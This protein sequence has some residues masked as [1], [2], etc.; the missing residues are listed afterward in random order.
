MP[1]LEHYQEAVAEGRIT[2]D[3][4][5][6]KAINLLQDI[7]HGLLAP[8][9]EQPKK[10]GLFGGMF[11]KRAAAEPIPPVKGA[12][13]WGGV[14]RGKTWI[15]DT[16]YSRVPIAEKRRMH[17]HHFMFF[18]HGEL[19][20]LSNKDNPLELI[21]AEM[22]KD[23]RLLCID[24]FHVLDIVDAMLLYGLLDAMFKHGVTLVTTSNRVPDDLYLNGLQRERFIPAIG[25]IKKYTTVL[26]LDNQVDYRMLKQMGEDSFLEDAATIQAEH[27]LEEKF[28][29]IAQGDVHTGHDIE[30]QGRHLATHKVADNIV[31][32]DFQT[33]C[34]TARSTRDYIELAER[35]RYI[36]LSGMH[37]LSTE[38]EEAARRFL[39]LLDELYDR[40][41]QFIFPTN[42]PLED[43]YQGEK[44]KFE[45][46]RALSR[47]NEM[48]SVSY[49]AS[50]PSNPN[51]LH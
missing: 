1:L 47:L 12:Y 30:V 25:L 43:L 6:L 51:T 26:E 50:E 7:W 23:T 35:F 46:Q 14:G 8:R 49:Q 11:A 20:K 3:P 36:M 16:F 38:H 28:A 32:F 34:E 42:F 39:N 2:R 17:Y 22:A 31:W 9:P 4:A 15:M 33:L 48:R 5:Q 24:E 18:I 41:V 10:S 19:K 29:E 21:V 27:E 44:L 13:I 40:Q 45:F 37:I